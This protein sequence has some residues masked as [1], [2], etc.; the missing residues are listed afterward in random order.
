MH[1]VPSYIRHIIKS[2]RTTLYSGTEEVQWKSETKKVFF[3]L[4]FQGTIGN[5]SLECICHIRGFVFKDNE[6]RRGVKVR[7]YVGAKEQSRGEG[8]ADNLRA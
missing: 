3:A 8:P 1:N 7:L 6:T 5:K 2:Y 4:E